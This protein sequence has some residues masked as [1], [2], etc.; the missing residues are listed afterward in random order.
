VDNEEYV[1]AKCLQAMR[2][3]LQKYAVALATS[4]TSEGETPA[5]LVEDAAH[6]LQILDLRDRCQ[7]RITEMSR[8]KP[9][10]GVVDPGL[11]PTD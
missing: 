2:V 4:L 5:V 3:E 9:P 1:L 8:D 10:S 11:Y 6:F 7:K